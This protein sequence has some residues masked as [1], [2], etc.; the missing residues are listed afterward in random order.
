MESFGLTP[1][2]SGSQS[3]RFAPRGI[4]QCLETFL[5]A[6]LEGG[7]WGE[8]YYWP[9]VGREARDAA[10]HPT[11][12]RMSSQQRTVRSRMSVGGGREILL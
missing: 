6:L 12:Q 7:R 8:G 9:S 10:T 11:V 2:S 3:W 5:I 1:E 4:W